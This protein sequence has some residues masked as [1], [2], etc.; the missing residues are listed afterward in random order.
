M[1]KVRSDEDIVDAYSDWSELCRSHLRDP[2]P[3]C[4][5]ALPRKASGQTT[6]GQ[7]AHDF[8]LCL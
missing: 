8:L 5:G 3:H 4:G 2:S 7:E 6:C 1:G